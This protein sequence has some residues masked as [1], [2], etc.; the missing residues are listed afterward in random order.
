MEKVIIIGGGFGGLNAAKSMKNADM[1]ILLLDKA[2][3]HVFQPL[4]YQ[5]ASAALAPSN[6]AYPLREI[7]KNQLNT[8]VIMA[9]VTAIDKSKQQ[10]TT[11]SGEIL[12]Y[13]YLV[14]ATGTCHSYFGND[15][16][17]GFAPGLKTLAD[18]ISIREKLLLTF[19]RAER[20]EDTSKIHKFLRFV[21]IGGGP[22]GVEMAGAIAEISR[23]TLFN[24]FRNI[25]PELSEIYL[26]EG[27]SQILPSYP[28]DL[29]LRAEK[30]LEKMG[31]RVLTNKKVTN[32]DEQ[33]VYLGDELLETS[34]IIWA[35]GNQA[36][37]VLKTLDVPLDRQGRV[38]VNTDCSLPGFPNVF[39]IGDCASFP[40]GKG[41][42]LPG[43]AQT[44]IQQG[45]YVAKVIKSR[46]PPEKRQPFKYFD[47]GSMA[48][49]G[50]AKAIAVIGKLKLSGFLAWLMW[51]FVHIAHLISFSNRLLV[52]TQWSYFYLTGKRS[53]R[54]VTRPVFE[55]DS[56][57][58]EKWEK[59]TLAS[60]F[61]ER[62]QEKDEIDE[63]EKDE[64]RWT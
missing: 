41:G 54:L 19:E 11:A 31:V 15:Q 35:A 59:A 6:I 42:S 26:I 12:A 47:K 32:I 63:E 17:E 46:I 1:E 16:W 8:S 10:I 21:I 45:K 43:V 44:A 5:V 29:A 57:L 30:D 40:N 7:L 52:M 14:I 51:G 58:L 25:K 24:N 50:Q 3:H 36:G 28:A 56:N 62:K 60:L 37:A 4:L 9:N 61:S 13:D 39:L 18:A 38:P 23:K 55:D 34:N 20:C 22:T 64:H 2:N 33:G 49:I 27:M 48:T 53:S